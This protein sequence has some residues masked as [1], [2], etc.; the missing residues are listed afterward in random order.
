MKTYKL[1]QKVLNSENNTI[2]YRIIMTNLTWEE[3]KKAR[4]EVKNS[5]IVQEN[6]NNYNIHMKV[7]RLGE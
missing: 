7:T 1:V 4:K 3:A 6:S 2:Q 5:I